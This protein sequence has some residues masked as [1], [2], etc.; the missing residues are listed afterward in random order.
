MAAVSTS[1]SFMVGT[2]GDATSPAISKGQT[3]ARARA[4]RSKMLSNCG[5]RSSIET[6]VLGAD[7]EPLVY[8]VPLIIRNTFIDLQDG[9]PPSLDEF[10]MERKIVSCPPSVLLN[11][12]E[13]SGAGHVTSTSTKTPTLACGKAGCGSGGSHPVVAA[14]AAVAAVA[15]TAAAKAAAPWRRAQSSTSLASAGTATL[16][17]A[18]VCSDGSKSDCST[19]DTDELSPP[20]T[21]KNHSSSSSSLSQGADSSPD[22]LELPSVGSAGHADGSCKPCAFLHSKGCSSGRSCEFCHL[23]DAGEKKRRQKDKRAFFSSTRAR[24]MTQSAVRR[25]LPGRY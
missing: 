8:P 18:A 12:G 17:S 4:I 9:R 2:A 15:A 23:C 22:R 25:V 3:S 10:F 14:A 11:P 13:E 7:G 6:A 19:T 5:A 21:P 20:I 24:E 16:A 1:S